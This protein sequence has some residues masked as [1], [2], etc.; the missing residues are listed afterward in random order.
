[1]L[2]LVLLVVAA[3]VGGAEIGGDRALTGIF[4]AFFLPFVTAM[5]HRA[6]GDGWAVSA[7]KALGFCAAFVLVLLPVYRF[8][9]FLVTFA[10]T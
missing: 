2:L 1:M 10:L 8:L 9:L 5:V 4:A 7:A 3:L 6:Y